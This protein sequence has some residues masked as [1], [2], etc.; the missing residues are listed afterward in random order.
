MNTRIHV[1][2]GMP[3]RECASRAKRAR[4]CEKVAYEQGIYKKM[5]SQRGASLPLA[6]LLFLI[7]AMAASIV[8]SAS[9][10]AAGRASQ[11]AETDQAYYSV[12][13]AVNLFRDELT[14]ADGQGHPVTVAVKYSSAAGTGSPYQVLVSTDGTVSYGTYN[15]LER[16]AVCLLL[17]G[18]AASNDAA[19]TVAQSYFATAGVWANW[20]SW[21]DI[22]AHTI[23][24]YDLQHASSDIDTSE[25]NIKVEANI[26]GDGNLV[27]TF[28]KTSD[29]GVTL[30][31]FNMT[32]D[33]DLSFDEVKVSDTETIKYA[34]VTW[35]PAAVEKG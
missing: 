26:D 1:S 22:K 25:L 33:L 3:S 28:S 21:D 8:L 14:G 9:T 27:L 32:C 23:A 24:T 2:V 34:T 4:R 20:P 13:S 15:L 12:T 16:A 19:Q 17:G 29:E 6:L 35:T 11:L 7:C 10:A 18:A 30:A 5:K 31:L